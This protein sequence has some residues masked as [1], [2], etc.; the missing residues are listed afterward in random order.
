MLYMMHGRRRSMYFTSVQRHA[1]ANRQWDQQKKCIIRRNAHAVHKNCE[2]E[3]SSKRD[4]KESPQISHV[5]DTMT[6]ASAVSYVPVRYVGRSSYLEPMHR[7]TLVDDLL[8][9][10]P[11]KAS[12]GT[13][14]FV[15]EGE[16]VQK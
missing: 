15:V 7:S 1:E 6:R 4:E 11:H 16:K 3:I 12:S 13:L 9:L 2:T 8:T 5:K 14:Q 10:I